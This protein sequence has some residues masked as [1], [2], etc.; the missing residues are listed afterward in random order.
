MLYNVHDDIIQYWLYNFNSTFPNRNGTNVYQKTK[1]II[2][3]THFTQY[4]VSLW[5]FS[6]DQNYKQYTPCTSNGYDL[7]A[8]VK[9]K[10]KNER[11]SVL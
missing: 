5:M 7:D 4:V 8:D 11:I 2:N 9:Y 6:R 10:Y 3:K 1:L